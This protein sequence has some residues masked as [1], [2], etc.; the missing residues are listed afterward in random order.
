MILGVR[1]VSE[2]H[3]QDQEVHQTQKETNSVA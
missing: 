3:A 1:T 2:N